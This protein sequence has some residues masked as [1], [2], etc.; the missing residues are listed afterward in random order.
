MD[1]QK[2]KKKEA[3][4]YFYETKEE[5][6]KAIGRSKTCYMLSKI[7]YCEVCNRGYCLAGKTQHL[8]RIKHNNAGINLTNYHPP[9]HPEAFASKCVPSP[10]AFAQQKM[11]RGQ[12][13]K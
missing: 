13:N 6:K 8:K 12:A 2:V 5:R 4:P 9:G 11:P 1:N 7:W 10:R 3:R